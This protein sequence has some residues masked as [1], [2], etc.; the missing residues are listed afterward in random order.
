MSDT[1]NNRKA[2][3]EKVIHQSEDSATPLSEQVDNKQQ[4]RGLSL[5]SP[6]VTPPPPPKEDSSDKSEK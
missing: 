4:D 1:R 5:E 2:Q 6:D 3:E